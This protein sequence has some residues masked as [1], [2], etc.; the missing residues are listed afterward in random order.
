[1]NHLYC[2]ESYSTVL[3]KLMMSFAL[4]NNMNSTEVLP[5]V[6]SLQH[7]LLVEHS[8]WPCLTLIRILYLHG[9]IIALKAL[10][11]EM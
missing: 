4:S 5:I 8:P 7:L 3:G 11:S 2:I 9:S 1:M 10:Q 6:W